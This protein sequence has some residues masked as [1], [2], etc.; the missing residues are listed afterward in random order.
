MS[1]QF[2]TSMFDSIKESLNKSQSQNAFKDIM[3]FKPGNS[4]EVRLLPNIADPAKTFH[5]YYTY[6]W[7]SFAT[8][9]YINVV[10][11]QSIGERDPISEAVYKLRQSGTAEEKAK[12]EKVYRREQWLV[13]AYVINDPEESENNDTCKVVRYGKQLH[14]VIFDAIEGEDSDQF[15]SRVFDLSENGCNFRIRCDKQGDYPT[16]VASKF[17]MPSAIEGL[18]PNSI[19]KIYQSV[20]TL[21]EMFEVKSYESLEET[22]NEHF[23]C[24][25]TSAV[26]IN[27]TLEENSQSDPDLEEELD[28]SMSSPNLETEEPK[29]KSEDIDIPSDLLKGLEDL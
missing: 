19:E 10:S 11:R 18:T 6:G 17:L 5:H 15:G 8:G 24:K 22:F 26:V 29:N 3:R 23:H 28:M 4:Y 21:D 7:E 16:Y 9:Q 14:K 2:T 27:S 1:A 25:T 20:H 12:A 13:N